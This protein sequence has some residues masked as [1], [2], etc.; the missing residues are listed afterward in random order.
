MEITPIYGVKGRE[1]HYLEFL[2][3][4]WMDMLKTCVSEADRFG[5]GVDMNLGTGWPFGGPQI[6]PDIAASRLIV[7]KFGLSGSE[8]LEEKILPLDP[9]GDVEDP[10]GAGQDVYD[11]LAQR[12]LELIPRRL[13]EV[14]T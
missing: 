5:M 14:L 2:S 9:Q 4:E 8:T 11:A 1:E 10:L 12:F 7:R 13:E 6:S 3:P